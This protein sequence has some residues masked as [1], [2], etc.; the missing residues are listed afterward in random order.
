M[1]REQG[2]E[3]GEGWVLRVG[4]GEAVGRRQEG[5]AEDSFL[6]V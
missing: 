5:V 4:V 1:L 6:A 2:G 3:A